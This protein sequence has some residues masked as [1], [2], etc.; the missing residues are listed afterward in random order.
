MPAL[1]EHSPK[2]TSKISSEILLELNDLAC[3]RGGVP[4]FSGLSLSIGEGE[5]WRIEG[6]NGVGKT[7]LLRLLTG[8]SRPN[9]GECSWRGQPFAWETD[10]RLD[11]L[12]YIGHKNA[13]KLSLTP[14]E[15]LLYW[16]P[17]QQEAILDA[18]DY[19]GIQAYAHQPCHTLSAGQ[20][21]RVALCR[22]LLSQN[23]LWVLDEPF[24]A[25]DRSGV[26]R[27][28]ALLLQHVE[29]GKSVIMTTHHRFQHSAVRILDLQAYSA[30][31]EGHS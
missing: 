1:P 23:V 9:A 11:E 29:A 24:T 20:Q 28:E 31:I 21:Q 26:V 8:L 3:E 30:V 27:L 18:L 13:V 6:P 22:L 4:L 16:Y 2:T 10:S 14:L 12:L 19:W 15:N 7:S 5:L 25:I 17:H